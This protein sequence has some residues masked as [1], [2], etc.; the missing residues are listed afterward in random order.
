METLLLLNL[1]V[2]RITIHM[3]ASMFLSARLRPQKRGIQ[4]ALKG[5][6]A[7][8]EAAKGC[9]CESKVCRHMFSSNFRGV[10]QREEAAGMWTE[11]T[12]PPFS[13]IPPAWP[14]I[15]W[16]REGRNGGR[17]L[18]LTGFCL[19]VRLSEGR[20]ALNNTNLVC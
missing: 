11:S 16:G 3:T 14:C 19:S 2:T 13:A 12:W 18:Q 6:L 7:H 20:Y 5:R 9:V 8:K 17:G 4:Q 15:K 1:E 10:W